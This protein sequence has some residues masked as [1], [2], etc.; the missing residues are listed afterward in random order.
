MTRLELAFAC[1]LSAL[2]WAVL[3]LL[4]VTIYP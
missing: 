1:V 3:I 4:S 2:C